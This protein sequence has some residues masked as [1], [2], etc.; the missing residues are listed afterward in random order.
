MFKKEWNKTVWQYFLRISSEPD[1]Q[2]LPT[3]LI[4]AFTE[5]PKYLDFKIT[6]LQPNL[7]FENIEGK[8]KETTK[9]KH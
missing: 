4:L 2:K 5:N 1:T 7:K 8:H 9:L 6:S 3:S